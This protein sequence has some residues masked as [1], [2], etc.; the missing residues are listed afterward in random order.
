MS[1]VPRNTAYP[2]S[3]RPASRFA[4]PAA[5]ARGAARRP[6]ESASSSQTR[7]WP[8]RSTR[9]QR[10]ARRR[11]GGS[12]LPA[13]AVAGRGQ[14]A[15]LTAATSRHSPPQATQGTPNSAVAMTALRESSGERPPP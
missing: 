9:R 13:L 10:S 4:A 12:T 2:M 11:R 5:P 8:H 1:N 6:H 7:A 14:I 3:A 15:V